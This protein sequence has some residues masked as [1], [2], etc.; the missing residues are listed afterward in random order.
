MSD[1]ERKQVEILEGAGRENDGGSTNAVA[2]LRHGLGGRSQDGRGS[3]G[4]GIKRGG[5]R[6]GL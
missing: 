3:A 5:G 1:N 6:N 2:G 4:G